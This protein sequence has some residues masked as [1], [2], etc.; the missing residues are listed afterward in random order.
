MG[1]EIGV[2]DLVDALDKVGNRINF[3]FFFVVGLVL[4][5]AIWLVS[6]FLLA[7]S[8]I[9][10]N[11]LWIV[12]ILS[13]V[14]GFVWLLSFLFVF[15]L[16]TT[17]EENKVKQ[18][19]LDFLE[20]S[21]YSVFSLT[22]IL[23]LSQCCSNYTKISFISFTLTAL[24][25]FV[26]TAIM[27]FFRAY[28]WVRKTTK[29]IKEVT[30]ELGNLKILARKMTSLN[31]DINSQLDLKADGGDVSIPEIEVKMKA[32][33]LLLSEFESLSNSIS[34]KAHL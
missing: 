4:N 29:I 9:T 24:L 27:K 34:M 33:D 21:M 19:N 30:P 25:C 22:G 18:L 28:F 13:F 14:L 31:N 12:I 2:S 16:N 23:F 3:V 8:F 11:P 17:R 6:I 20:G 15:V 32:L 1:I 26:T 10:A 5:T 7:R